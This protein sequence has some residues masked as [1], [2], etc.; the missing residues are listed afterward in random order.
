MRVHFLSLVNPYRPHPTGASEDIRR[1]VEALAAKTSVEVYAVDY[2]D[3][4][5]VR[6]KVP[7]R[8]KLKL[9]RRWPDYRPWRWLLPL[10]VVRRHNPRLVGDLRDAMESKE[11]A[12]LIVEGLQSLGMWLDVRKAVR[13]D[14]TVVLRLFNIES[15]YHAH[16]MK[17][18]ERF[19][20]RF[21]NAV[22]SIQ[23]RL[24]ERLVLSR[25]DRIHAISTVEAEALSSKPHLREKVQCV[26]PLASDHSSCQSTEAHGTA[27]LRVGYF[28]DLTVS[29]N[30]RG[31][32]WFANEVLPRLRHVDVELHVAGQG[33]EQLVRL[34]KVE[35]YGFVDR[36][37]DFV[38]SMD[39]LVVPLLGG[40]GVKVKTL[41]SIGFGLPL[42]ATPHA[43]EGLSPDMVSE[44]W[45]SDS[46]SALAR[47]LEE[48]GCSYQRALARAHRARK[49][50]LLRHSS[51][52]YAHLMLDLLTE[53]TR[54][55]ALNR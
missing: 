40:A 31:L 49:R 6:G 3:Q 19:V 35:T 38:C 17:A 26:L 32:E 48:I 53:K 24:C 14:S 28:G 37:R 18:S 13:N 16:A 2:E 11:G 44:L 47:Y 39:V 12:M 54:A 45:V 36:L 5:K 41:D 10:P 27:A 1:R 4:L 33:A 8:A 55:R 22:T 50:L 29:M 20:E 42:I 9:Y 7:E 46:P 34:H 51:D 43:V 23:Y 15:R 25:F 21:A 52:A 30:R